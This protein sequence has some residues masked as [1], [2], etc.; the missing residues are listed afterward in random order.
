MLNDLFGD[1]KRDWRSASQ[2]TRVIGALAASDE[3]ARRLMT[4]PGIGPRGPQH[5]SQPLETVSS[6]RKSYGERLGLFWVYFS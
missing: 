3:K 6:S 4:I 2:V 1:L 5:S